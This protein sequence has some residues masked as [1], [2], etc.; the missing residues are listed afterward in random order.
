[1]AR[2]VGKDRSTVANSVRLLRLSRD[3]QTHVVDGRL[4]SGHARAILSVEPTSQG[5]LVAE[6]L[7]R[8]LSVRETERAARKLKAQGPKKPSRKRVP[9]LQPYFDGV[10]AELSS[11]LESTVTVQSRGRKGKVI[12]D[13]NSVEDLRR[14]RDRIVALQERDH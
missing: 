11:A 10:A 4:S 13:F 2:R 12:I 3:I 6:I 7:D 8:D 1:M 5:P 9:S 14:L